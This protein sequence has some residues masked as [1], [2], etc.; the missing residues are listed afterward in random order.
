MAIRRRGLW[1]LTQ[2]HIDGAR[3]ENF[4]AD[5]VVFA[6]YASS[7]HFRE[8]RRSV[9]DLRQK[10]PNNRI[11][12]YNMGLTKQEEDEVSRV[13]NLTIRRFDFSSYPSYASDLYNYAF[14]MF[15]MA[16]MM[17]DGRP[18]W[19]VDT[20]VTFKTVECVRTFYDEAPDYLM[21][22]STGF[23][24]IDFTDPAM[25]KYLPNPPKLAAQKQNGAAHVFMRPSRTTK[26]AAKWL[27]LCALTKDCIASPT[28]TRYCKRENRQRGCHRYDQSAQNAVRYAVL[29]DPALIFY[30]S[31]CGPK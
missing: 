3:A 20:S 10:F 21:Q 4:W 13:C 6:M 1:S 23:M 18:F 27:L 31:I 30:P 16:E 19:M 5:D 11:I 26:L 15:I 9:R 17:A 22:G 7:D 14:K 28:A 25:F 29:R 8:A 24:N 2:R 12:F